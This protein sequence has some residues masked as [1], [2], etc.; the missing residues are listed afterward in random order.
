MPRFL[1]K[2]RR[3]VPKREM[4]NVMAPPT[5]PQRVNMIGLKPEEVAWVSLLVTLLRSPD[6]VIA[7]L[8]RQ[9]LLYLESTAARTAER[10][11]TAHS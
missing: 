1:F 5:Q 10:A 6:P 4:V 11:A 3:E 8:A 2:A 7:E 9:A